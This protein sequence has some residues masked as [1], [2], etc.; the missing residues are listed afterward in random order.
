MFEER[1]GASLPPDCRFALYTAK[2]LESMEAQKFPEAVHLFRLALKCYPVMTGVVQE[3]IRQM[4]NR[5]DN[6][7]RNAG[8]EFGM[9]AGQMKQS[10]SMLVE[11]RQYAQA[12]PVM[13]QLCTLLP[14]D[15]ELLR[16]R[17]RLLAKM[18]EQRGCEGALSVL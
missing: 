11:Q 14:E 12:L 1:E 7:A 15:L 8:G 17:Q 5:L 2:A 13:Q 16:I 9:L 4:K 18:D 3:V 6:P 10:L